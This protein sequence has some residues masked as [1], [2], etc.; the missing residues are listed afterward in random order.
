M[1]L[2]PGRRKRPV[3]SHTTRACGSTSASRRSSR[4]EKLRCSARGAQPSASSSDDTRLGDRRR[5]RDEPAVSLHRGRCRSGGQSS[6]R[7]RLKAPAT[8]RTLVS[9]P[10]IVSMADEVADGP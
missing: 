10:S 9:T 4:A 7:S 3:T 8:A 5:S 6:P 1:G 2:K